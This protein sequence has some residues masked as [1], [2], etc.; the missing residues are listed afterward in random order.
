MEYFIGFL[1]GA[2]LGII[3]GALIWRNNALKAE[4]ALKDTV[5]ELMKMKA[6]YGMGKGR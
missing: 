5:D 4:A 2:I 6:N 3:G 1:I